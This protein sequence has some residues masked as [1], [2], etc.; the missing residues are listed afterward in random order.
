MPHIHE[1]IDFTV[2]VFL[3]YGSTVFLRKHDK[4]KIWLSVGGHIELDEDPNQAA[5][6]EVK[7]EVGI[8]IVLAG[9]APHSEES[10]S[11]KELIAP[12]FLNRHRINETHE[13]VTMVYFAKSPTNEIHQ[14][15]TEVSDEFRWFT[16]RELA[17]PA[18]G[19]RENIRFYAEQA[20]AALG[21]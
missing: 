3:V 6:R 16:A 21:E 14:G 11:F 15:E 4:Y 2:E 1:K 12:R 18:Y 20:L 9:H 8:D 10:E 13:H 5:V 17:D 19:L 7:K